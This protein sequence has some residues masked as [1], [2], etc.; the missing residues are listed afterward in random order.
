MTQ[1]PVAADPGQP[2]VRRT[3]RGTY[4]LAMVDGERK[5]LMQG[6]HCSSFALHLQAALPLC[7]L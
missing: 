2:A 6:G 1:Q 7:R 3:K 4:V 5:L